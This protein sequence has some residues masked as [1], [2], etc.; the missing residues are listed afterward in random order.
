MQPEQPNEPSEPKSP[1]E[2]PNEP[3]PAAKEHEEPRP[4]PQP[5]RDQDIHRIFWERTRRSRAIE[6]LLVQGFLWGN[7]FAFGRGSYT[8]LWAI[9]PFGI[10][11][12][13]LIHLV[14]SVTKFGSTFDIGIML[15]YAFS[16]LL[17]VF[18]TLYWN[19]GTTSNFSESL[20][21]LDAI[22]FSVG[23]LSTAGTG[24]I[25]AI[26]Q[27]ARGLQTL[28]MLLDIGL[29][30]FAVSLAV[31]EISSRMQNNRN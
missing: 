12:A 15:F 14:I 22:Y 17:A 3:P 18:S 21:R 27:A 13:L 30:V 31:A 25:S 5:K 8:G 10:A 29:V 28:Q 20:T 6:T 19:Y 16:S 23:T 2:P 7:L 4:S 11:L 1:P 9:I 26:S 24:N